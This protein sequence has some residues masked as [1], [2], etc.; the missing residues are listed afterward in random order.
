MKIK[1][2]LTVDLIATGRNIKRLRQ[3]K[4]LSVKE[5]QDYFGFEDPQAI[6]KWQQG[7][8]LPRADH[9][10]ALSVLLE[11]TME[12]ILVPTERRT[13]ECERE[14]QEH[15]CDSFL[16][17]P[18]SDLEH[19]RVIS[20]CACVTHGTICKRALS[21]IMGKPFSTMACAASMLMI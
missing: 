18:F 5:L 17:R 4:G 3:A 13:G 20:P 11:V 10:F 6:Y 9:L 16:L 7:R 2:F 1:P 19:G 12:Q 14:P 21:I 8:S 15:D